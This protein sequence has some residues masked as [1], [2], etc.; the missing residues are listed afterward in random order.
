MEDA[1]TPASLPSSFDVRLS[2]L[3][4]LQPSVRALPPRLCAYG[5]S[6]QAVIFCRNQTD[7]LPKCVERNLGHAIAQDYFPSQKT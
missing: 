3:A 6:V 4:D 2:T 1:R 5:G 7:P